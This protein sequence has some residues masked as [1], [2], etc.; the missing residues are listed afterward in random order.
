MSFKNHDEQD[1]KE[2]MVKE[3]HAF[4][5]DLSD[6]AF[7]Y[8]KDDC[9]LA[10]AYG[11][12]WVWVDEDGRILTREEAQKDLDDILQERRQRIIRRSQ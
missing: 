7:A 5:M 1:T 10:D 12:D 2:I 8:L 11:T 6:R 3:V 4:V 9:S